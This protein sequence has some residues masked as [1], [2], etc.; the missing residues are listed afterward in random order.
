MKDW[1]LKEK[2]REKL[3]A[4]GAATLSDAELIAIFLRTGIKGSTALDL[5]RKLIAR[6]GN[7]RHL[8]EAKIQKFCELP[9]VGAAKYAELQAALELSRRY[10]LTTLKREN[11][12]KNP[13]IIKN[14]LISKLRHRHHETLA[15]VFL[16][17]QLHLISF[18]ELFHGTINKVSIYPRCIIQRALEQH[19]AAIILA[20]NHPSGHP[21]PSQLD[22]DFTRNIKK[23]LDIVDIRLLDHLVIGES[24]IYSMAEHGLIDT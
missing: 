17:H 22:I 18:E 7:I 10:L 16:T 14:Y 5:A 2:P 9:G 21:L 11:V 19:A 8:L 4:Y 13:Q 23:V 15:C 20:H 6:F 1:P 3:L 24:D 12:I